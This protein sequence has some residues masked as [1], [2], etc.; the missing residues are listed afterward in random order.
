MKLYHGSPYLFDHFDLES[1]GE[2]TGIKF[3]FGVYLTESESSAVHY[4]Q[5]RNT[6]LMPEH[7][8]Y[9]VEIP[10]LNNCNHL[11][12]AKPVSEIIISKVEERL[13]T[14]V[15]SNMKDAGKEFRKW[16]GTVLTGAKKSGFEEEKRAAEFL[17][18]IGVI[19]NIWPT[20]QTKPDGPKN[21]AVFNASHVNIVQIEKIEIE[22][23]GKK[24][25]LKN[26]III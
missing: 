7:Y 19:Y 8:L 15:P 25:I 12:S 24:W 14:K 26:R 21:I 22:A 10:E 20:A 13:G 3:G 2:G 23:K 17:D 9:T 6:G 11:V 1:A 5:P 18:S 16:I 4:S